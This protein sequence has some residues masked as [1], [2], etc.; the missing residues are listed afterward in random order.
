M[1]FSSLVDDMIRKLEGFGYDTYLAGTAVLNALEGRLNQEYAFYSRCSKEELEMVL[2]DFTYNPEKGYFEQKFN[3]FLIFVYP[4]SNQSLL[5]VLSDFTICMLYYHP[6]KG[7][8]DLVH[9]RRDLKIGLI[10]PFFSSEKNIQ[11]KPDLILKAILLAGTYEFTIEHSFV[12]Y[13]YQHQTI[14]NG[15]DKKERMA[16]LHSFFKL[17][18]IGKLLR[19]Y[20][21]VFINFFPELAFYIS[22]KEESISLLEETITAMDYCQKNVRVRLAILFHLLPPSHLQTIFFKYETN[23]DSSIL[24]WIKNQYL[25]LEK[26]EHLLDLSKNMTKEDLKDYFIF[27]RTIVLTKKDFE[28]IHKID[29]AEEKTNELIQTGKNLDVTML[30]IHSDDLIKLGFPKNMIKKVL[31]KIQKEVYLNHLSNQREELLEFAKTLISLE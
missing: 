12:Q 25:P 27:R 17:S 22:R 31:L 24:L 23:I 5:T 21:F 1:F 16:F 19:E 10:K 30:E 14:L 11:R 18:K 26:E 4:I 2:K 8:I 3:R 15:I 7:I 6:N 28:Q 29:I 13:Y 20:S 9:G